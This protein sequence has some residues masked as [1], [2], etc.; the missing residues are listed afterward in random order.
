MARESLVGDNDRARAN[1]AL[2][3]A[4]LG[5]IL[6]AAVPELDKFVRSLWLPNT[7][8]AV[9]DMPLRCDTN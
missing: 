6:A 3:T 1:W 8:E 7:D 4:G 9:F 2:L 5:G